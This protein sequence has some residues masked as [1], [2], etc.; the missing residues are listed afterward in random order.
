MKQKFFDLPFEE[1]NKIAMD[2]M[3]GGARF[4]VWDYCPDKAGNYGIVE[5]CPKAIDR[6]FIHGFMFTD[7]KVCALHHDYVG[8]KYFDIN[9]YSDYYPEDEAFEHR[10]KN[11]WHIFTSR[12]KAE[13]Y[14]AKA[15]QLF[16][17]VVTLESILPEVQKIFKEAHITKGRRGYETNTPEYECISADHGWTTFHITEE[18][19][20]RVQFGQNGSYIIPH[21]E[22]IVPTFTDVKRGHN[23]NYEYCVS[24][25][26][27]NDF[28]L[29][30]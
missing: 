19:R 28:Y 30:K 17:E 11:M 25:W 12:E 15:K 22:L 6:G 7:P 26:A 13:A 21:T 3:Y 9:V 18:G 23:V 24:E 20:I 29:N 10:T 1:R 2:R 27:W 8:V 16:P 5:Q 14:A 4:V